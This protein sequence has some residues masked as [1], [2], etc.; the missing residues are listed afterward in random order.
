MM[1]AG[2]GHQ[3]AW[4]WQH[5]RWV[6]PGSANCTGMPHTTTQQ[7]IRAVVERSSSEELGCQ[8]CSSS[9]SVKV[10]QANRPSQNSSFR[11]MIFF[12]FPFCYSGITYHPHPPNHNL[13]TITTS[14]GKF[15]KSPFIIFV[16]I[17][18]RI[19]AVFSHY[20]ISH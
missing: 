9:T 4:C 5:N 14:D 19:S 10:G 3:T 2:I 8:L 15:L 16:R 20:W 12:L 1:N 6:T 17:F 7:F 18:R 11:E 13:F